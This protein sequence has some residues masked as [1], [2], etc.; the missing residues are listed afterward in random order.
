MKIEV[1]VDLQLMPLTTE[2]ATALVP[3]SY[4]SLVVQSERNTLSAK[5]KEVCQIICTQHSWK[6]RDFVAH[7]CEKSKVKHH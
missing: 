7:T 4:T 3:S 1:G 6:V 5:K 2:R